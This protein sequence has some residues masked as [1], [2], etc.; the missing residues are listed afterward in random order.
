MPLLPGIVG[1]TGT[2]SNVI[3]VAYG[4]VNRVV[5]PIEDMGVCI[6]HGFFLHVSP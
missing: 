1:L 6:L 2:W 3:M 5:Y 4:K